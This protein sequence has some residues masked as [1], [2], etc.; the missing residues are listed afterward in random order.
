MK[1][2][3]SFF[4]ALCVAAALTAGC[5]N[6]K[7]ERAQ[8]PDKIFFK[9]GHLAD[10]RNTWNLGALRFKELVEKN[11][12]GRILVRVYPNEQLGSEKDLVTS[13]RTGA[14]DIGIFGETLTMFGANKTI[15]MATPYLIRDA[16]HLHKVAGGE[17]GREIETQILDKVKLRAIAYFERGPRELTSN[18]PVRRPADLEGMKL[19]IPNVP[20]FAAAWRALGAM[21]TPTAFSEV[22]GSLQQGLV[23]GQENPYALIKSANLYEV[24]RY[25]NRT[26]HVRSWIYVC[27]GERQFAALPPDLQRVV[28]E[29]GREMQ[30]YEN[31]LF[32]REEAELENFLKG[33]M[34]FVTVDTAAF[35]AQTRD[36]VLA[37]LDA[38]QQD[39]YHRIAAVK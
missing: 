22:F 15:M 25:L 19:R 39:M 16:A 37:N 20:L 35:Q 36:A 32:V 10:E 14:A 29:A 26:S 18:R 34:T 11:S 9:F 2:S 3:V 23:D 17:I 24:Q 5:G 27:I 7:K 8:P 13:I 31:E 1:K 12:G 28:L 4:I 6:T 30:R 21:P 33:R 38:E